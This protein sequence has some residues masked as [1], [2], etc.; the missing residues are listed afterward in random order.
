MKT[1]RIDLWLSTDSPE[2]G[3]ALAEH[4]H[5]ISAEVLAT[6]LALEGAPDEAAFTGHDADLGLAFALRRA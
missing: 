1:D 4:A 3:A 2:L 5:D 6:S